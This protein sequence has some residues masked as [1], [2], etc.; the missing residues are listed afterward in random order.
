MR[1]STFSKQT[2]C[3][4]CSR[5][6]YY[7][8]NQS[9]CRYFPNGHVVHSWSG[10]SLERSA[11]ADW[12]RAVGT[13]YQHLWFAFLSWS[14]QRAWH[15]STGWS[16]DWKMVHRSC[17]VGTWSCLD[18]TCRSF[19]HGACILLGLWA[20]NGHRQPKQSGPYRWSVEDLDANCRVDT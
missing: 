20:C 3:R 7:Y 5:P 13:P 12:L 8:L 9:L 17:D 14:D 2:N 10:P 16:N 11:F 4:R 18:C 19:S 15:R 6:H 1:W